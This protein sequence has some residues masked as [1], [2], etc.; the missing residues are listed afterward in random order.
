VL[1]L[2]KPEFQFLVEEAVKK[3]IID[4]VE[5]E[6]PDHHYVLHDGQIGYEN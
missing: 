5:Y 1:N 4:V 6:S 2:F 3:M